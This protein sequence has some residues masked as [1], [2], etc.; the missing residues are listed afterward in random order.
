M[1]KILITLIA[2]I[3]FLFA[4]NPYCQAFGLKVWIDSGH[5]SYCRSNDWDSW[6]PCRLNRYCDSY[7]WIDGV[8]YCRDAYGNLVE[9]YIEYIDFDYPYASLSFNPFFSIVFDDFWFRGWHHRH[10]YWH[11]TYF[12]RDGYRYRNSL[13]DIIRYHPNQFNNHIRLDRYD[14]DRYWD[15]FPNRG[16]RERKIFDVKPEKRSRRDIFQPH[17]KIKEPLR[18]KKHNTFP[19]YTP[20]SET[21]FR[22]N[23]LSPGPVFKNRSSIPKHFDTQKSRTPNIRSNPSHKSFSPPRNSG[24]QSLSRHRR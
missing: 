17:E 13:Y 3:V 15:R 11:Y 24:K 2:S 20:K 8:L 6:Y 5:N 19:S 10:G 18:T 1:K 7:D 22:P 12:H 4:L 9:V 14:H 16:H 21:R 23:N